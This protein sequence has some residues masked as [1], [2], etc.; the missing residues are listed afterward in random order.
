M[1]TWLKLMIA[2]TLAGRRG[3][4]KDTGFLEQRHTDPRRKDFNDSIYFAGL[5]E[6]G[7]SMVTR[8]SFRTGRTPEN[9]LKLD[10]PGDGVW[11]FENRALESGT[12]FRQGKLAYTCIEP[13]HRWSIEYDGPVF[14]GDREA[15]VTLDLEWVGD[16]PIADFEL[17]GT[18]PEMVAH[19]LAARPWTV[20]FFRNLNDIRTFHYE[21][22]GRIRGSITWRGQ[23]QTVDLTGV[24]DHSFGIRRWEQWS[25]HAWMV[26]R[27]EDGR[28]FNVSAIDYRFIDDLRAAFL[29]DGNQYITLTVTPSTREF[30]LREPLPHNLNFFVQMPDNRI[31]EVSVDMLKFFPFVMDGIY[32]IRQAKALF[33]WDGIKGIGI[34]EMGMHMDDSHENSPS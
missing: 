31:S 23:Q 18:N 3:R 33:T 27:L 22:A 25:R 21:Q 26:G 12:G 16:V 6:D 29:W 11:G 24:R 30:N 17:T 2:R 1:K 7:F 14:N 5:S 32:R 28:F 9:W 10:I 20:D 19:L 13:G 4:L 34:A 8:L 15:G